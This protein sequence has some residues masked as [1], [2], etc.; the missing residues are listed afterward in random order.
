M[1]FPIIVN[2]EMS[3]RFGNNNIVANIV[4]FDNDRIEQVINEGGNFTTLAYY[5]KRYIKVMIP[6]KEVYE[7]LQLQTTI[8]DTFEE[9]TLAYADSNWS[10]YKASILKEKRN[11]KRNGEGPT[12]V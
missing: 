1:R 2:V 9:E 10:E 5:N 4:D 6:F 7:M 3:D 8:L 12:T 11:D